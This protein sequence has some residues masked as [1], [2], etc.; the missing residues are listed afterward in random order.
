MLLQANAVRVCAGDAEL[1]HHADLTLGAGQV[2]ALVG[3]NGAGKST[4]ARA[5]AG[6]HPP[7]GGRV[8]W[9]GTDVT[10]LGGRQ[11]ARVRAFVPQRAPVPRGMTVREAVDLGRAPHVGPLRRPTRHD[12]DVAAAAIERVG[13][14]V[15][16]E[17]TLVTLS[18]GELQRVRVA[19]ALAQQAPCM[20]LDEPTSALDLGAAARIGRLLRDLADDEGLAVL[21][22]LQDLALAAAV[23]DTVVVMSGG[24]TV[25]AGGPA[26]VFTPQRL[27]EI[28]DVSAELVLGDRGHGTALHVDWLA[29]T[30]GR[31]TAP[32]RDVRAEPLEE[33]YI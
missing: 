26:E 30:H 21:V 29:A 15:L 31:H 10:R 6:L 14:Q 32:V 1:V 33:E 3:P 24:R 28:W 23:A 25:A 18:G 8:T 9:D 16:S 2:V 17:R 19:V 20:I 11:L 7:A 5:I 12:R 22:V 13:A 27:A 4:F